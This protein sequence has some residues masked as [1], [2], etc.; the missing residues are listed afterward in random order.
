MGSVYRCDVD[1]VGR[2]PCVRRIGVTE[3]ASDGFQLT[4]DAAAIYEQHKVR[5]IFGPLADATLY[6]VPLYRN[7]TVLDVACGT[8]IVARKVRDKIGPAARIIGTDINQEMIAIARGLGD[9]ASK[10]CDWQIADAT[11]LPFDSRLF[12][13]AFCQQGIQYLS[14]K[15]RALREIQRVLRPGGRLAMTVWNGA[16]DYLAPIA[17]A[18]GRHLSDDA[19]EQATSFDACNGET[20]LPVMSDIG[21]VDISIEEMVVNRTL[22]ADFNAIQGEIMGLPVG[23]AVE[24]A[25]KE[26]LHKI[27]EDALSGLSRFREGENFIIPETT[28]LVQANV[29]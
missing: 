20:L 7:D 26:V 21:Y 28:H 12:S 11:N 1:R 14:D 25:G 15:E 8:G 2:A 19:A 23:L 4:A 10:S 9:A 13:I 27:V 6:R 18:L 5:A 16:A 22:K 24:Q 17:E 29:Q 3:M